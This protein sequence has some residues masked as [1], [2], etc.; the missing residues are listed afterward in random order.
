MSAA[1][2]A[3]GRTAARGSGGVL[4]DLLTGNRAVGKDIT[5]AGQLDAALG[6]VVCGMG[7]GYTAHLTALRITSPGQETIWKPPT[8]ANPIRDRISP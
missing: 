8:Q 3:N 7:L 6:I 4:L 1:A 2:A 5:A